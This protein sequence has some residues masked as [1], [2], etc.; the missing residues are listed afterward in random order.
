MYSAT[1]EQA[2]YT[3]I[4][5]CGMRLVCAPGRSDVVYC[6]VAVDA[7][8]RDEGMRENGI[9]HYTEHLSFK[10][11]LGRNAWHIINRMESVG[12]E[13]N[14]F[15]GK[16]ETVYYCTCMKEHFARAVDVLMDIVFRS[17]YPEK[18]MEKEVEVV[19]NEIESY[20]DSPSELI[21]DEFENMLFQGHP[22]GRSILGDADQLRRLTTADI[23]R[24]T[25]RLYTPSRAV[26]FVYGPIPPA[27]VK[28]IAGKYGPTDACIQS[29]A[30]RTPLPPYSPQTA[31]RTLDTHQAHVMIGTRAF[32][33]QHP[34]HMALCLLSNMLGGSG[35]NSRLNQSLRERHGLVYTVESNLTAYTDTGVWA[36]YFG[37]D[38]SQ[39]DRCISL[40]QKE[41]D[42]LLRAP[43]SPATLQAA[44]RQFKGQLGLSCDNFENVAIGMGKRFLHYHNTLSRQQL[45][46]KIDA[47]TPD[48]LWQVACQVFQ[49]DLLS[50]LKYV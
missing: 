2:F 13:L 10:G 9:A 19:A 4:L 23:L 50:V 42:K 43:L 41:L 45:C 49:P 44:K 48:M 31:T 39:A 35:M 47:L 36:V 38:P 16:E 1:M 22:L 29:V 28:A 8:T 21:Y 33:A 14:A 11:T 18:E 37:C 30:P 20:N 26:L 6:G 46:D 12:G 15:T 17:T 25:H 24:F 32:A 7:G 5:P 3:D 40:V 27:R 34:F